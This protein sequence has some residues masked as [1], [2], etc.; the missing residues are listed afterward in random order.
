[1]IEACPP[2]SLRVLLLST[3]VPLPGEAGSPR[4]YQL[5]RALAARHEIS[6]LLVDCGYGFRDKIEKHQSPA[7]PFKNV[8]KLEA[9]F[10]G[11]AIFGKMANAIRGNPWFATHI[12]HRKEHLRIV[13][14][15]RDLSH[16]ADVIWIDGLFLLQ[17]A[18]DCGVP[19]VLD[20][21]DFK[22]RLDFAKSGRLG[23]PL[24]RRFEHTRAYLVRRY[25]RIHLRNVDRVVLNSDV[26]ATQMLSDIGVSATVVGNG[27]DTE[28]FAPARGGE[29][30]PGSPALVFVGN[31]AYRP[32]HDAAIFMLADVLPA[33]TT[34]F[35]EAKAYLVGPTPEGGLGRL[36]S[37]VQAVGYV[38]DVRHYYNAADIFICPLRLGVGIKNKVLEAAAMECVIVASGVSVE[39]LDLQSGTHYL[40]ADAPSEYV[41]RIRAV[42]ANDEINARQLGRNARALVER[43]YTWAAAGSQLESLLIEAAD[44]STRT[45]AYDRPPTRRT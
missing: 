1:M 21:R 25:E 24:R 37:N 18:E 38:E 5:A 41:E 6:L 7:S 40:R 10:G 36:P 3:A 16:E 23:S 8:R 42:L 33:V 20:P 22:S 19:I 14:A 27:C 39:G 29:A 26:D 9:D 34:A 17:Y 12:K 32:N 15:V 44:G 28:F 30:L 31:F 11:G 43:R 13:D 4:I 45:D 35:P 2:V